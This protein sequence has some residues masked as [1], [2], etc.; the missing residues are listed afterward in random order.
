MYH[1]CFDYNIPP[2]EQSKEREN[3][4]VTWPSGCLFHSDNVFNLVIVPWALLPGSWTLV[5]EYAKYSDWKL[6]WCL[7]DSKRKWKLNFCDASLTTVDQYGVRNA[8]IGVF[9]V[10]KA[11][12]WEELLEKMNKSKKK[13]NLK[14]FNYSIIILYLDMSLKILY[15]IND[16]IN[17]TVGILKI[18]DSMFIKDELSVTINSVLFDLSYSAVYFFVK[19]MMFLLASST[20]T[21][22]DLSEFMQVWRMSAL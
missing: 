20:E 6:N 13:N 21:R 1:G 4:L 10:R 12:T 8:V 14:S 22:R 15:V 16:S 17:F 9:L 2:G 3:R 18:N 11:W 5:L 19:T 7:T